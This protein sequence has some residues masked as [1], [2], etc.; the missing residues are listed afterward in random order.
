MKRF[1]IITESDARVLARGDTVTLVKGGHITPLAQDTLRERG[2]TLVHEGRASS[3]ELHSLWRQYRASS[4]KRLRDR[5]ILSLAP[6]VKF[7]VYR[8]VRNVPAHVEAKGRIEA[9]GRCDVGHAEREPV[10]RVNAER[11]LAPELGG[12]RL[13]GHF[14]ERVSSRGGN[15]QR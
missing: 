2:V 11:I 9:L 13:R 8:K 1:D 12:L 15:P 3:D 6:M 4:D 10:Q 7:I 5:L 14:A